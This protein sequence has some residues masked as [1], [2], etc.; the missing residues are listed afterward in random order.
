MLIDER[1]K[2][3]RALMVNWLLVA[4]RGWNISLELGDW[5][6]FGGVLADAVG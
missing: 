3:F 5:E 6:F 2:M 1:H 4:R